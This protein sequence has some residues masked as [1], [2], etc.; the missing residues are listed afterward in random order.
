MRLYDLL[1]PW[2]ESFDAPVVVEISEIARMLIQD[3]GQD[4]YPFRESFPKMLTPW[5]FVFYEY[6]IPA[7]MT[8]GSDRQRIPFS[9]QIGLLMHTSPANAGTIKALEATIQAQNSSI[10]LPPSFWACVPE[11]KYLVAASQF[12]FKNRV[13][14]TPA[15]DIPLLIGIMLLDA[16]GD[17]IDDSF[18]RLTSFP[19]MA[20]QRILVSHDLFFYPALMASSLLNCK[21]VSTVDHVT[22][23][24]VARS[25]IKKGKPP[26]V[27]YKTLAVTVP[28]S[29]TPVRL[30]SAPSGIKR[31]E[32]IVRGHFAT[33]G[34]HN[35][36]F[37]RLTGTFY[38]PMHVRGRNKERKI[39]KDYR[40]KT[41]DAA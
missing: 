9:G 28:G 7:Y 14:E 27:T 12:H 20:A 41:E 17:F 37:G 18:F 33:Y 3:Q 15:W 1:P 13:L 16:A 23:E 36:L 22:P 32:H 4:Q 39:V 10:K 5:P 31:G 11:A 40:L 34:E 21:N 2:A 30:G 26:G 24:K 29:K 8:I 6:A 19:G 25:R 35:K 38:H